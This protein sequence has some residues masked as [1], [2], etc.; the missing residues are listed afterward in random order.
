MLKKRDVWAGVGFAVASAAGLTFWAY[1]TDIG[2]AKENLRHGSE[3]FTSRSG[4]MEYA[5]AGAGAPV[6][7][8]HGTGGGFDQGLAFG[9]KIV[10]AGRQ[11]ISPSRYGYLRSAFP[12]DPSPESQADAFVDL[13]DE[14]GVE[15]APVIGVSAGAL[16]AIEFAIRHPDRC[17]G[18][19]AV[20]PA[21]YA[22]NRAPPRPLTPVA[23]WIIERSLK[24]N[25]LF[26]AGM[27]VAEDEMI[28]TLLATDPRLVREAP[29]QEKTR[30]RRILKSILPVSE[31]APGLLNDARLTGSPSPMNL[32]AIKVPTLA[33]SVEDD[34]FGTVAAARHI[35]AEVKGARLLVIPAGGHIWI[36]HDDEVFAA[37]ERFLSTIERQPDVASD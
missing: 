4:A 29:E 30:A 34:G 31:R 26:W 2:R 9:E 5:V 11:V 1:L 10:A 7:V 6:L 19:I 8:V 15:R 32:R 35:A 24:S 3:V 23:T 27:S 25:F 33:I 14:L 18:L 13:L 21:A 28:R 20:V 16:S 36:G 37:I 17:G 12:D 22:P